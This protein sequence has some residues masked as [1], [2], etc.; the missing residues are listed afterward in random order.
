VLPKPLKMR[1]PC[2]L[3]HFVRKERT[4][5]KGIEPVLRVVGFNSM[6]VK[7]SVRR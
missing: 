5:D 2:M 1:I 7:L 6:C 4:E 3:E